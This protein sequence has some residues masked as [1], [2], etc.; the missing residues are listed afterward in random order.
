MS[1]YIR[2]AVTWPY[3]RTSV[4]L[5]VASSAE[6][7]VTMRIAGLWKYG[8]WRHVATGCTAVVDIMK[9]R[10]AVRVFHFGYTEEGE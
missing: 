9:G 2:R 7:D 5:G 10:V 8:D 4:T 6:N 3:V 1:L